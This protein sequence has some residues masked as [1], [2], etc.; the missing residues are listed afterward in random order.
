MGTLSFFPF[1]GLFK[2]QKKSSPS[3]NEK[4]VNYV[5]QDSEVAA[6]DDEGNW[7]HCKPCSRGKSG[8][9]AYIVTGR[10]SFDLARWKQHKTGVNHS[11][12]SRANEETKQPFLH[13]FFPTRE[14]V[15]LKLNARLLAEEDKAN[16]DHATVP[17]LPEPTTGYQTRT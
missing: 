4:W 5:V 11:R 1:L 6:F 12:L 17:F 13:K 14:A 9:A 16:Q 7:V 10:F 15:A 2:L 8:S 3:T